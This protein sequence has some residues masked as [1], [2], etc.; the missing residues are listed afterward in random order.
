MFIPQYIYNNKKKNH[1]NPTIFLQRFPSRSKKDILRI[2]KK[3]TFVPQYIYKTTD[4]KKKKMMLPQRFS[5][6][7]FFHQRKIYSAEYLEKRK[8]YYIH[9]SICI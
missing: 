4:Y 8:F 1:I 7:D 3:F 6:N 5:F 9:L 2:K